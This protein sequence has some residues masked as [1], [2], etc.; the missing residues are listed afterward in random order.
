MNKPIKCSFDFVF[1]AAKL[2]RIVSAQSVVF[3]DDA[4]NAN[5][6]N[7]SSQFYPSHPMT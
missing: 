2:R 7:V 1:H 4:E 3:S 6:F 5:V